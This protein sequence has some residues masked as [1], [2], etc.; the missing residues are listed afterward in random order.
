MTPKDKAKRTLL[1]IEIQRDE[2][3]FRIMRE[4]AQMKPPSGMTAKEAFA[5]IERQMP[6]MAAIFRRQAD[7]AVHYF[8]ECINAARQPS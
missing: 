8:H 1:G 6:H 5:D 7:A 2:L 4:A 3:A